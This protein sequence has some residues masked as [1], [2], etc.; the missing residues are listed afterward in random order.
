VCLNGSRNRPATVRDVY[1]DNGGFRGEGNDV[2]SVEASI[3]GRLDHRWLLVDGI[4]HERIGEPLLVVQTFG[5]G[6]NHGGTSLLTDNSYNPN[7]AASQYFRIDERAKAEALFRETA[8]ARGDTDSLKNGSGKADEFEV[9]MP[10]ALRRR[11]ARDHGDG[12]PFIN[13]VEGAVRSVKDPVLAGFAA[14]A[15]AVRSA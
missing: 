8:L 9:R 12:D 10:Q 5:L 2:A 15:L 11:P 13:A 14:L 4:L 6:C 1:L 3:R 7:I